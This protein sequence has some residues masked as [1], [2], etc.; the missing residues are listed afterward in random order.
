MKVKVVI[1]LNIKI[2]NEKIRKSKFS[3]ILV[4]N[5]R[6]FIFATDCDIHGPGGGC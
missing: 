1:D 3:E 2:W 6:D 5:L 4:E